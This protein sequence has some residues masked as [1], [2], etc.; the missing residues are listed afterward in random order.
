MKVEYKY[1]TAEEVL[2]NK[3]PSN[4]Y[5]EESDTIDNI[6]THFLCREFLLRFEDGKAVECLGH[7]GGEPEDQNFCRDLNWIAYA[8]QAAY[9]LGKKH[10][11][12]GV[13]I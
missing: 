8:L 6:S 7:D 2:E 3:W 13:T 5:F 11:N 9:E 1:A 4:G 12:N 10:A